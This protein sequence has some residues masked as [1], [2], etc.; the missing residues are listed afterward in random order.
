MGR[1]SKT[2]DFYLSSPNRE[3]HLGL[4]LWQGTRRGS[5]DGKGLQMVGRKIHHGARIWNLVNQLK[6][7]SKITPLVARMLSKMCFGAT[8]Q[9]NSILTDNLI[10][11]DF[12]MEWQGKFFALDLQ[13]T[14]VFDDDGVNGTRLSLVLGGSGLTFQVFI[15]D[16][17]FFEMNYK[18]IF[19]VILKTINPATDFNHM[20]NLVLTEVRYRS[21]PYPSHHIPIAKLI[22]Q[23]QIYQHTYT[24]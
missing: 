8:I 13:R 22:N 10:H 15:H 17:N 3:K 24:Y 4:Q 11:E 16:P 1:V 6:I 19:P 2:L 12:T 18:P 23:I 14:M 9:N 20:Y 7:A 5:V 21:M